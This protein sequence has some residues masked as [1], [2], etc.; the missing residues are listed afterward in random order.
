MGPANQEQTGLGDP[1]EHDRD[2]G[3]PR[4][5]GKGR[6]TVVGRKGGAKGGERSRNHPPRVPSWGLGGD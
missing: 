4:V 2:R 6:R 1:A 5:G 3:V